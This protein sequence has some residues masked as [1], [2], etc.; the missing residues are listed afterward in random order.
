ML[1]GGQLV[2]FVL[3]TDYDKARTFYEGKLGL[4]FVSLDQF[5][6]VLRTGKNNIRISKVANFKPLPST[7]LGW[8]VDD[9]EAIVRW[10]QG[11]GVVTE[12]YAFVPDQELGVWTA[13][14]GDKVAWFKDPDDNVLSVSHHV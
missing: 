13:P 5:A 1:N 11:R 10:L 2:G 3:T 8:D 7:V 12:K 9:V 4:E 14:S 6:L